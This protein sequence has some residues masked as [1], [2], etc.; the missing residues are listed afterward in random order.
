V[1]APRRLILGNWPLKLAAL[2]LA[3]LLYAGVALSE[4][5][6]TWEGPVPI[7]VLRAPSGGALLD[8]PGVVDEI[9]FR[10]PQ[11]VADQLTAG[12]FRASIDLSAV[13]PRVGA[14]PVPVT[15]D[16]FPADPRVRVVDHTPR[17]VNVRLDQVVSRSLPVTIDTGVVP[18]DIVLS[19]VI[20]APNQVS[21]RGASS[22][23]QNV[24]TV[25]GR[26]VVDA[27]GINIDQD[28]ALEAF[29]EQGALVAGVQLEPE[30]VRVRADVARQ[31]AFATL[32]VVPEITG[33]PAPGKRVANVSVV[34]AAVTVSGENPA[35]R[36]L[37]A[38]RTAA[39]DIGGQDV[40]LVTEVP[41]AFPDE[42]TAQ[43]DTT[44]TVVVTF[45]DEVAS[46][47]YQVGTALVGTRADR[48]YRIV[49]PSITVLVAGT[50][51]QLD[52]LEVG[53]I[54]VDVPVAELEVG[55]HAVEPSISL[56]RGLSVARL[57]PDAVRV[58][59]GQ[60]T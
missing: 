51:A 41:L 55:D 57:E 47:S 5:T 56:P 40:E 45:T 48:T 59:V 60:P 42:V 43:G 49:N 25:Q 30:S 17:S 53:D 58:T 15:V 1:S 35:V 16:V 13:E 27:S 36:Q 33:R 3:T 18:E 10:A 26:V 37:T 38:I 21:V 6:R 11:E 39:V 22:R 12:S 4:S 54:V 28:V 29:D 32:P 52:E 14:E 19:P 46:R 20:A 2:G 50:Q 23:V 31:Q 8:V 34:P 9:R 24:R 7:E 44:V